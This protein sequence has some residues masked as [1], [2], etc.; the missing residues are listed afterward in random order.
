MKTLA[1][2][3]PKYALIGRGSSAMEY[4]SDKGTIHSY[5][6]MYEKWFAPVRLTAKCVMEIGM[7]SG[8]SV[9]MWRDYFPNAIIHGID[10]WGWPREFHPRNDMTRIA[11]WKIDSTN[12]DSVNKWFQDGMFDIII[13]DADHHPDVQLE[14][15]KLFWPKLRAGGM[16]IIE[17]VALPTFLMDDLSEMKVSPELLDLRDERPPSDFHANALILIQKPR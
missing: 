11:A 1:S 6:K 3:Y 12:S 14:V 2:I 10:S 9:L 8:A 5:I 7:G 13:D 17:D 16:Y 15:F 4:G